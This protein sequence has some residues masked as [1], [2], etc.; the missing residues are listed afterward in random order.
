MENVLIVKGVIL[1][2]MLLI[3]MTVL[4]V[5]SLRIMNVFQGKIVK[6]LV[7]SSLIVLQMNAKDV[8]Q[9]VPL[10]LVKQIPNVQ[11]AQEDTICTRFN[12]NVKQD[13]LLD[14]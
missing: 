9:D 8:L 6:L 11:L 14:M 10:V 5:Y 3:A 13:V 7:D 4:M 2:L 1:V 12:L